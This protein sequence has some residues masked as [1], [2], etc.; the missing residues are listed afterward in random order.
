[1]FKFKIFHR[2]I[3]EHTLTHTRMHAY[4]FCLHS[5][6]IMAVCFLLICAIHRALCV[7][8]HLFQQESKRLLRYVA[9]FF[10]PFYCWI[11][12]SAYVF[13]LGLFE[14][15]KGICCTCTSAVSAIIY[16]RNF[17]SVQSFRERQ[18][19]QWNLS[20]GMIFKLTLRCEMLTNEQHH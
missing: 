16:V 10:L 9:V 18:A 11:V 17:S 7:C 14:A 5:A 3:F 4:M 8:S 6:M 2:H 12:K 20:N 19:H 1:M 15:L 13:S